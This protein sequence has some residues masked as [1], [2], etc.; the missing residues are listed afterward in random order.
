[1]AMHAAQSENSAEEKIRLLFCSTCGSIDE[2]PMFDGP[3]DQDTLAEYLL[4]DKHTFPS[5]QRHVSPFNG[6]AVVAKKEWDNPT[7]RKA[8]IDK[9][10]ETIKA[11]GSE[12][13]GREFYDSRNTF[14]EDAMTCWKKHNRTK[15]C[16]DYRSKKMLIYPDTKALRKEA[17]LAPRPTYAKNYICDHCPYHQV[18]VQRK[19]DAAGMYDYKE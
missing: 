13:L 9:A 5:G 1:M 2:L 3:P 11:G 7:Y 4:N 10:N 15:N 8:I 16:G 19:R 18:V 14:A 6:F 12:G 17:G